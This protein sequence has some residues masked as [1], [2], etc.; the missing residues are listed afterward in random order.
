M[1]EETVGAE[2]V[3]LDMQTHLN[4]YRSLAA[5]ALSDWANSFPKSEVDVDEGV[6][7]SLGE[8]SFDAGH[9][10]PLDEFLEELRGLASRAPK[11]AEVIIKLTSGYS[12][13]DERGDP[14]YEV[15]YWRDPTA[16]ERQERE[17]ANRK[18]REH[19]AALE[20]RKADAEREEYERLR[21]KFASDSDGSGGAGQTA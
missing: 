5:G 13:D 12:W 19:N 6:Y 17:D 2:S 20:Q 11:R 14:E 7:V 15:G 21:A 8:R 18:A 16:K 3:Y 10:Q 4:E 9:E 1:G